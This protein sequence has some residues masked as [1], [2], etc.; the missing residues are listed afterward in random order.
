MG[1]LAAV[2]HVGMVTSVRSIS[3]AGVLLAVVDDGT[4]TSVHD[5]LLI[6]DIVGVLAVVV[7][8]GITV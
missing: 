2:V 6:I 5:G 1:V 8:V 4:V 3:T 7:H